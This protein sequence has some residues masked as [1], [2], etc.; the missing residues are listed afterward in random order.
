MHSY[1]RS[2]LKFVSSTI[3]VLL[4][5]FILSGCEMIQNAISQIFPTASTQAVSLPNTEYTSEP[6]A[7]ITN[8]VL[9][10]DTT[11]V[12]TAE[13]EE[14][15]QQTAAITST[16]EFTPT[17]EIKTIELWVP[18]QFDPAGNTES[19]PVLTSLITQFTAENPDTNVVI[20]VKANEGESS[21]L[22]TLA[23]A[24]NAAPDVIPSLILLS[25]SEMETAVQ[26]GLVQ[27]I[28][29]ELFADQYTWYSYARQSA[30]IDST[31]YGIPIL[32]DALVLTYR[33]SKSGAAFVDWPD[34]LTRGMPIAFV[35]SSQTALFPTFIYKAMGGK[36]T[37]DQG[38]TYLDQSKLTDSLNFFLEGGQKGVFPPS[39]AQVPDQTQNWQLFNDGTVNLIIS[40]FS[41]FRHFESTD[42]SAI[43]LPLFEGT[44]V[45][46]LAFT[47]N[48]VLTEDKPELQ[49]LAVKFAERMAEP[50]FNDD[51]A[52][53][54]GY[55]PVRDTDHLAWADNSQNQTMLTIS[56]SAG[57][58]PNNATMNKILPLINNAV[59][60]VIKNTSSPEAA[61]QEAV[62]NL[63]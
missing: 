20:R 46:P 58:I 39:I 26:K 10:S 7:A 54:S 32:G 59:S 37:N 6:V 24:K 30:V 23:A 43:A 56:E 34:I 27:P 4:M 50:G 12:S 14:E 48:L 16:P 18:Q 40:Q 41:T 52:L 1:F 11:P 9:P 49:R 60:Q 28:S 42:I 31:V 17:P 35:P 22:N 21:T 55:L 62:A 5:L 51:W 36:T 45:Y 8:T 44:E 57:L 33:V 29:T 19:G 15:N 2:T 47:W 53:A 25:R 3:L 38:L 13:A 61:A 63:K